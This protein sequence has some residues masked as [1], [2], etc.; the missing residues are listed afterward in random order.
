MQE[1][2]AESKRLQAKNIVPPT[3]ILQATLKQMQSFADP[4]PAQ[5][6]FV[7][8]FADKMAS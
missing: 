3:F 6:P 2:I 8:V 1:S 5:N 4:S 7:T